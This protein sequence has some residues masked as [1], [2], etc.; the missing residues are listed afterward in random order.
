MAKS[1]ACLRQPVPLLD[2]LLCPSTF[3]DTPGFLLSQHATAVHFWTPPFLSSVIPAMS[4]FSILASESDYLTNDLSSGLSSS[5][6]DR[7]F[8]FVS[9]SSWPI[10]HACVHPITERH[11][12]GHSPSHIFLC[13]VFS[14]PLFLDFFSY[15]QPKEYLSHSPTSQTS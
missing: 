13:L 1:W 15:S 8:L 2:V 4:T 14:F 10:I 11:P 9:S 6:R 12:A 5:E 7:A 3:T